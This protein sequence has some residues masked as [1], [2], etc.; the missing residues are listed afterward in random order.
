MPSLNISTLKNSVIFK[1][2]VFLTV[3]MIAC[4]STLVYIQAKNSASS[5][6]NEY[7]VA[8]KIKT[9]LLATQLVG[10][11]KWKK[12]DGM[13][14]IYGELLD[15]KDVELETVY[16]TNDAAEKM[17]QSDST[18]FNIEEFLKGKANDAFWDTIGEEV[19]IIKTPDYFI[20]SAP[21]IDTKKQKHIGNIWAA[22]S[23]IKINENI[24][25]SQ[26]TQVLIAFG[27]IVLL[28]SI[29]I[30]LL[31]TV[32]TSPLM[33]SINT[34]TTLAQG[35]Y[36]IEIPN[37]QK[38]DE[39]GTMAKAIEVFKSNAI[40][41]EKAEAAQKEAEAA[42]ETEKR[43][44]MNEMADNFEAQVLNIVEGVSAAITEM[45][46]TSS[47]LSEI[48]SKTGDESM[49]VSNSTD[50]ASQN[51]QT[52]AAA[53]EELSSS[54][55][56]IMQQVSHATHLTDSADS[57]AKHTSEIVRSLVNSAEQIGDVVKLIQDI[58]EQTNLLALNATIESARA[59]EAGKGFAV[60]A[61]E[62]KTL[63]TETGKAT[64]E[65]AQKIQEIQDISIQSSEAIEDIATIIIDISENMASVNSATEQQGDATREISKNAQEAAT[66]SSQVASGISSVSQAASETG[67]IA[68]ETSTAIAELSK[69]SELL[70][71]SITEFIQNIR[72]S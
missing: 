16:I 13:H 20:V 14:S 60:V 12:I 53:S 64:E 59:G 5:I 19:K 68:Q 25:Q 70:K 39:I 33:Q 36:N 40:E 50:Q 21:I 9:K 8:V 62:V 4:L 69:Q 58:A 72:T 17:T 7:E 52:V 71:S 30:Y 15:D 35:N 22:W 3:V 41:K 1:F 37:L 11:V 43:R 26:Q 55:E 54:I 28:I 49:I 34:M 23:K 29:V 67:K 45:S 66:G 6:L 18:V 31:R 32:I 42:A 38:T 57:K 27:I 24:A 48:A 47:H 2:S 56:S 51:V 63:A 44:M 10:A 46:A 61:N 65:I